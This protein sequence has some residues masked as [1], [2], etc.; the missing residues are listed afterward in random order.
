FNYSKATDKTPYVGRLLH[1]LSFYSARETILTFFDPIFSPEHASKNHNIE[2]G[3]IQPHGSSFTHID[4]EKF[5]D[6][7]FD[8][9][10]RLD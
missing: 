9:L 4:L 6:D 8:Y 5:D 10:D 3:F 7:L 2:A 1:H